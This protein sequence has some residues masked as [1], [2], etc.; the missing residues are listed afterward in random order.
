MLKE[1]CDIGIVGAMDAEIERIL[2]S[3]S[4]VKEDTVCAFKFFIGDYAKKRVCLVKCGIGKV[5]A[6]ACTQTMILAYAPSLIVN[7]GVGGALKGG[8]N[9]CD[10]VVATSLV[11]HDMDTSAIGDPKGLVSGINKIFFG[12]DP[13][14]CEIL[15]HEAIRLGYPVKFGIVATGDRFVASAEDKNNIVS[16]F[17][18][19]CCEMEG[20]AVAQTAFIGR[21]PFAVIRAISDSAD[22]SSSMDYAKFLPIAAERSAMLTLAL[23]SAY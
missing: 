10:I 9:P 21:T 2:S 17:D 11:Q 7:T 22:G 5:F 13:R 15:E 4:D 23:V 14:A 3:L 8:L 1:K 6:A 18:A 20:C 19:D 16:T 12:T